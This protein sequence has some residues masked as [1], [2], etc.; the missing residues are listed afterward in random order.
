MTPVVEVRDLWYSYPPLAGQR[1]EWVL[2]GVSFRLEQGRFV[3]LM[4]PSGSGKST[5]ALALNG[6]VPQSTGGQIRGE[7]RIEGLDSKRHPVA[8]LAKRVGIVFQDPE[9]QFLQ[10][11]VEAEVAFGPENLGLARGEI[12]TRVDWALGSVG[13]SGFHA[14][15]PGHLSGGEKQRVAI[16]SILAMRP[17]ILVLDEPTASLDPAGK[18]EIFEIIRGLRQEHTVFMITQDSEAVAEFAD[19]VLVLDHGQIVMEGEPD[20]VFEEVERL[21][22]LGLHAPEIR[23]F[24][25]CLNRHLG[26]PAFHFKRLDEAVEALLHSSIA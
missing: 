1:P 2:Q 20:A 11:S 19:R 24:A 14:R 13:L 25:H 9:T 21:A 5:L 23:E 17:L 16:A 8:E 26:T 18:L 4:G 15:S 7:V 6:S 3:C 10:T 12:R 22:A